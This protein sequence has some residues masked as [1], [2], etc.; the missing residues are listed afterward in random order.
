MLFSLPRAS[1]AP[2]PPS[3]LQMIDK[4]IQLELQ[5]RIGTYAP[6]GTTAA[7]TP[8]QQRLQ[9]RQQKEIKAPNLHFLLHKR[10]SQPVQPVTK[11]PQSASLVLPYGKSKQCVPT[12]HSWRAPL[13]PLYMDQ[14]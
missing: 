13:R 6:R 12:V 5:E 14:W 10:K 7:Y 3:G 9:L 2:P 4:M 8:T 11:R 1:R